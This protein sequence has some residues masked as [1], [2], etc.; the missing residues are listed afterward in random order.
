MNIK[1]EVFWYTLKKPHITPLHTNLTTEVLIIGGGMGGLMAAHAWAARG[2]KVILIEKD[3]CG[4]GASGKSSGFISPDAEIELFNYIHLFGADAAK[5]WWNFG[6]RGVEAI[7]AAI[8]TYNL[9]CDYQEQ[10][11]LYIASNR[12]TVNRI[13]QEHQARQQLS[14]PSNFYDENTIVTIVNGEQFYAGVSYGQCFSI[15]SYLFCQHFKEILQ[16]NPAIEIYEATAAQQINN[17]TITTSTGHTITADYIIIAADYALDTLGYAVN[18][19]Y[20]A[21]TFLSVSKPLSDKALSALFLK[22]YTWLGIQN[23]CLIIFV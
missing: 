21:Q 1:K 15:T 16:Q 22:N 11:S 23:W 13:K 12:D 6:Q 3:F 2:K 5:A 17:H 10:D 4:S 9:E 20:H 14:Y 18:S 7:R 19:V 8:T